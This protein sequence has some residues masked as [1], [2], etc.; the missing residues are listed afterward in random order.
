MSISIEVIDSATGRSAVGTGYRMWRMDTEWDELAAGLV[1]EAETFPVLP[2]SPEPS[3]PADRPLRQGMYRLRLEL[4]S[5]F[6]GLGVT[7]FQSQIEVVFRVLH[8]GQRVRL[9]MMIAPSS[10]DVNIVLMD[11]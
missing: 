6:A 10:C 3:A 7:S 9:V 8:P 11:E 5:Y 4:D 2:V 1:G